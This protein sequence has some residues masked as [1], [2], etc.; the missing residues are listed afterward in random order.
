LAKHKVNNSAAI[1]EAF[2]TLG[3]D[4]KPAVV[5]E[6]LAA[7]KIKVTAQAVSQDKGKRKARAS[8]G[9]GLSLDSLLAAKALVKRSGW[10][11]PGQ[12]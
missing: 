7:K 6:S 1:R 5:A 3:A 8:N 10:S 4:A 11:R 2:E 9:D 12:L